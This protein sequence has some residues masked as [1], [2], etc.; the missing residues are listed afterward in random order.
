M[1]FINFT[2]HQFGLKDYGK[3]AK[4]KA[5]LVSV[6]FN[7]DCKHDKLF[8]KILLISISPTCAN[9]DNQ[10]H[11][12][13]SSYNHQE[14]NMDLGMDFLDAYK[15]TIGKTFL[16]GNYENFIAEMGI[17]G[18]VTI[19]KTDFV[20]NSKEYLDKVMAT[21]NDPNI[22]TLHYPG[23][24]MWFTFDN[25]IVP[26]SIDF[27]KTDKSV[28]YGKTTFD[29]TYSIKQFKKD[30]PTSAN[31]SFKLPQSLFELTTRAKG[32]N[33]EHYMLMRKSKDDP[34]ATPMIEFTFDNGKLIFL[35]FANF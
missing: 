8:F 16:Y 6:N 11:I 2:Q 25:S 23:I 14:N 35:L 15:L 3:L 7:E 32:A 21:A 9:H 5:L 34:N 26:S 17:P 20:I 28:T 24:D 22:V 18:K 33:F 19:T 10:P 13:T 1:I 12:D 31:P 29:T 27:R 4:Q 30:F